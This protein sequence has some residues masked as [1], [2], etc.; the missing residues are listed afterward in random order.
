M[1]SI[2]FLSALSFNIRTAIVLAVLAFMASLGASFFSGAV[3]SVIIVR[4]IAAIFI[5]AAMGYCIGYVLT[6]YVPEILAIFKI[7]RE[8]DLD[9]GMINEGGEGEIDLEAED[10]SSFT[11][12]RADELS[13]VSGDESFDPSEGKL[14]RHIIDTE[15]A[16]QYEPKLMAEAVRTMMSK[17]E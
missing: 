15:D 2:N 5:F 11:E 16:M 10:G 9:S 1:L 4:L 6:K 13:H 12:M 7:D 3:I 17:D 14:G 8:E